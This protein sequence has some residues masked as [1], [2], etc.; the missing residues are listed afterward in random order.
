MGKR[1]PRKRRWRNSLHRFF[2]RFFEKSTGRILGLATEREHLRDGLAV[3]HVARFFPWPQVTI[4]PV[5][6]TI[7]LGTRTFVVG[8]SSLFYDPRVKP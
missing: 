8:S 1:R 4:E 6:K 3:G 5:R 7:R 2:R